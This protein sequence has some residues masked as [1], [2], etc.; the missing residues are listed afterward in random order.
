MRYWV[1]CCNVGHCGTNRSRDMG[2][3]IEAKDALTAMSI[4]RR[5]PGVKHHGTKYFSSVREITEEEYK[6]RRKESAYTKALRY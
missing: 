2:L 3:A 1:V 6:K 4:A 5:F